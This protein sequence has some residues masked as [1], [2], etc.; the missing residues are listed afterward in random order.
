MT[1]DWNC[2]MYD[3]SLV[4]QGEKVFDVLRAKVASDHNSN[5]MTLGEV[6]YLL[7]DFSFNPIAFRGLVGYLSRKAVSYGYCFVTAP[8][9]APVGSPTGQFIDL[10]MALIPI[11]TDLEYR[12]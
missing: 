7:V 10:E 9:V 8:I 3:S 11:T 6:A 12:R 4:K 1:Q 5:P 2:Y